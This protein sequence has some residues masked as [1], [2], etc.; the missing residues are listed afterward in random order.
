MLVRERGGGLLR[1]EGG[2]RGV[3]GGVLQAG[4]G[5]VRPGG[6]AVEEVLDAARLGAFVVPARYCQCLYVESTTV[7]SPAC[8]LMPYTVYFVLTLEAALVQVWG[9]DATHPSI[10][11]DWAGDCPWRR[12]RG[13]RGGVLGLEAL[14]RKVDVG[15]S[16]VERKS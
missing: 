14:E 4:V 12:P 1:D 16:S 10:V 8:T 7:A 15:G 3:W 6:N 13:T 5:Y 9:R 2:G 11:C